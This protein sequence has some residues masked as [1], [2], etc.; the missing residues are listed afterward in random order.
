MNFAELIENLPESTP[1][2]RPKLDTAGTYTVKV[3]EA[4][5]G[6]NQ[7][8]T[9]Y[10]GFIKV[11]VT[12]GDKAT[13]LT[14]IY[15]TQGKDDAQS[16]RNIKPYFETL[17]GLGVKKDKIIDAEDT[18]TWLEVIQSIIAQHTK[19]ITRGVEVKY[20]L[21]LKEDIKRSTEEKKEFYKNVYMYTQ[22]E[23]TSTAPEAI[24]TP[25]V[26]AVASKASKKLVATEE[27]VKAQIDVLAKTEAED[28]LDWMD[29]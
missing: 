16:A 15:L 14:N 26:K 4:S 9:G 17:I 29:S 27:A 21:V 11:E 18:S 20:T 13:A 10:R 6:Q 5:Y 8:K 25:A 23:T 1:S 12:E 3:L 7:A 28:N 2:N 22:A 19:L 24:Y